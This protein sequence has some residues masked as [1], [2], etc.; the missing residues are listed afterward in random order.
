M[1]YGSQFSILKLNSV[2]LI[3]HLSFCDLLYCVVGFPHLIQAY[4]TRTNIYDPTVCYFLGMFR[5]LVAYADFN[6]IAVIACCVARQSLCRKCAGNSL[7]HDEHDPIFGGKK[8]YLAC[9]GIWLTS[10]AALLPDII[11]TTGQFG[12]TSSAYGCDN[13][14]TTNKCSNLGPFFNHIINLCAV[15]VFYSAYIINMMKIRNNVRKIH[16][17]GSEVESYDELVKSISMTLLLLTIAYLAFLLPITIFET[18]SPAGAL[19]LSTDVRACI[20]SWYWWLYGVNFIIYLTTN[21]RIK[22]AYRKFL[23]DVWKTF[24]GKN[25]ESKENEDVSTI[26]WLELR[27]M[28]TERS[29]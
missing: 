6:N 25:P 27:N 28:N 4:W 7:K 10:F 5:N 15:V 17:L 13:I 9:L 1:K 14:N 22:A 29:L 16:I 23:K 24:L 11:G 20:A 19:F 12:W 8:I 18:C 26:F 2:I 21:K 3:L